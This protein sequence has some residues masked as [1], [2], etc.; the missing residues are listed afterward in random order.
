VSTVVLLRL[1][2]LGDILL[3]EPVPR[4]L[5]EC[6]PGCSVVY[7]TRERFAAI[8]RG[9]PAVDRVLALPD[10]IR[11]QDLLALRRELQALGRHR[12]LDLHNTLRSHLIWPCG[13]RRL[14][15][16]RAQK[17]LLVH[18]KIL[19]ASWRGRPGPVWR[20]YLALAG[21]PQAP[22]GWR[23]RLVVQGEELRHSER[24]HD[25]LVPGAGFATKAWPA[26]RWL[27]FLPCLLATGETPVL[28]LGGPREIEL[29]E[30][31]AAAAPARV[32]NLCGR[33]SLTE[34]ARLVAAARRIVTGDTGLL[35]M[36]DAAGVPGVALFGGTTRELGFYPQ[37]A[38]LRVLEREL[39]CRPCSHVG[40]RACPLGHLAC[41]DGIGAGEV[42]E[43]LLAAEAAC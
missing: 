4:F 3:S 15:K 21:L 24:R 29:G 35:H 11:V 1:S 37:G 39:P 40:R 8:P 10:R 6:E 12:R 42:L 33:T 28:V 36:A 27:E 23:P 19:P 43:A 14:P 30:R 7:V 32:T 41:L 34:A 5:K 16:H 18:G 2:A 38:G 13:A 26:T 17:L 9:W 20:R 31:L 22:M 25:L